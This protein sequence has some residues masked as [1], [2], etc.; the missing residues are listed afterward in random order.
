MREKTAYNTMTTA[1][2]AELLKEEI[3]SQKVNVLNSYFK[4]DKEKTLKFL[5]SVAHCASSTPKLLECSQ[6]SIINAFM[7]C[8]ELN[9]FPSSVSGE[10]Y[11]LPYKGKAQFQL[12]YQW[13][14]TLFYRAWAKS[15][16][17]EIV[18][19]HDV[20]NGRYLEVNGVITH[21]PDVFN[22]ARRKTE[23]VWAYI[24]IELSTWGIAYKSMPKDSI[25]EIWKAFS[26]SYST[27]FSPW[28]EKND[29][30]LWMWKKTVL[31]QSAKLVPKNE[32]LVQAIEYDNSE[33]TS[34]PEIH[35]NSLL[36]QSKRPTEMSIENL[37]PTNTTT[38]PTAQSEISKSAITNS[39]QPN[40]SQPEHEESQEPDSNPSWAQEKIPE[41]N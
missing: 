12:G 38:W 28:K 37:L 34:F 7:K 23:A 24:V 39:E 1:L 15:I 8:A 5:N 9:I 27:D 40:G 35:K 20:D 22:P 36:E 13:L 17:A 11:I 32:L 30:E 33:D 31:K 6:D 19:Q 16:R 2:T 14:V 26:Q 18:R 21:N 4:R 41:K 29:P 10:A 3:K 25:L